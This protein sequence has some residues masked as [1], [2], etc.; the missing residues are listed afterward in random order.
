ML[1]ADDITKVNPTMIPNHDILCA[2]FPCQAF[3]ISGKQLGFNDT[4]G[5]LFFNVA[6]IIKAKHPKIVLMENVKNLFHHDHGNTFKVIKN[7]MNELGY[8]FLLS[9]IK[10]K[11]LWN[12]PKSGTFIHGRIC[13]GIKNS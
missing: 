8:D 1:P 13:Q 7:T 10:R 12:S 4:R 2:G 6:N 11:R 5:T 9:N 3:S